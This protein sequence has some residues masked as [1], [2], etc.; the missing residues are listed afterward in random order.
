M[1]CHNIDVPETLPEPWQSPDTF[2]I[3]RPVGTWQTDDADLINWETAC[4]QCGQEIEFS[5]YAELAK[6]IAERLSV[7]WFGVCHLCRPGCVR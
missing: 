3:F 7:R 1:N 2:Q 5:I 4:R 6:P